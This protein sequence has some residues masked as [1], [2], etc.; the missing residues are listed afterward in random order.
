MNSFLSIDYLKT[1]NSRQKKAYEDLNELGVFNQLTK[2]QPVLAGTI[3][4]GIDMKNSDLDI[5]CICK[6]HIT[7]SN[8]LIDLFSNKEGFLIQTKNVNG[9]ETTIARFQ[10]KY[11]PIEIF[12][13]NIPTKDQD[14]FRHLLIEHEILKEKGSIFAQ[15]V[16]HLKKSGLKT[17]PAFAQLLGLKG[18]PYQELLNFR[19]K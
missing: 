5:L 14:A 1:G 9:V 4:I 8:E 13:Q 12:A 15:K 19:L 16:I 3:P 2:Y 17:E 18:N 11:F 10:G 6:N 7:F